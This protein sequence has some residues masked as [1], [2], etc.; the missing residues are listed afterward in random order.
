[1]RIETRVFR[2]DEVISPPG[3]PPR[4]LDPCALCG[5]CTL[6]RMHLK[7]TMENRERAGSTDNTADGTVVCAP[8][9]LPR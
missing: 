1:M 7:E 4:T 6:L 9:S 5:Q 2:V 3:P 8:L